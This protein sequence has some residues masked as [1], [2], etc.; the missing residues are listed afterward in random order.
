MI[1]TYNRLQGEARDW[2]RK[3][4]IPIGEKCLPAKGRKAMGKSAIDKIAGNGSFGFSTRRGREDGDTACMTRGLDNQWKS[5]RGS[6]VRRRKNICRMM[7]TKAIDGMQMD[8]FERHEV[9]VKKNLARQIK[10][11]QAKTLMREIRSRN[12]NPKARRGHKRRAA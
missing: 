1:W 11:A 10:M 5:G 7:T 4:R 8:R 6:I 12:R 3:N 2:A 9:S